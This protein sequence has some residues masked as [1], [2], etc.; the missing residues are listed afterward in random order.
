MLTRD[1]LIDIIMERLAGA[2]GEP[3][4]TP[5]TPAAP[6]PA[7]APVRSR[8]DEEPKGRRFLSEYD[9]RKQLTDNSQ[10][11]RI[12]KDA[13]ISPLAEDWLTLRRIKIIRE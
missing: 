3:P 13:I 12:S 10:E 9:I 8:L 2:G 5:G 4:R 1:D 11:L 6:A 7:P